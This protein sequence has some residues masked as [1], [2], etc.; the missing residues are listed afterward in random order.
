MTFLN[1]D[2]LTRSTGSNP[3]TKQKLES[4]LNFKKCYIRKGV[5]SKIILNSTCN[6]KLAVQILL[7]R[8]KNNKFKKNAVDWVTPVSKHV[9]DRLS[10]LK[11][12]N[13]ISSWFVTPKG[14]NII[15]VNETHADGDKKGILLKAPEIDAFIDFKSFDDIKKLAQRNAYVSQHGIQIFNPNEE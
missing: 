11:K 12:A 10:Q 7:Q 2:F 3:L 8:N 6:Q 4:E 1:S 15:V 13:I 5:K 9:I 14:A